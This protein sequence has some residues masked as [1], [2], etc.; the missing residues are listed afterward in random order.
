MKKIILIIFLSLILGLSLKSQNLYN[1]NLFTQNPEMYNPS[2]IVNDDIASFYLTSR[3]QWTGFEGLPK[4]NAAGASISLD[5]KMSIGMTIFNS[6]HGVLNNMKARASY[7]YSLKL[8]KKHFLK[9]G[10]SFGIVHDRLLFNQL[11]NVNTN[12]LTLQDGYYNKMYFSSAFG[13]FYKFK[14]LETQIILPQ[15]YEYNELNLY[16][17]AILAYDFKVTYDVSVK[18]TVLVRNTELDKVQSDFYVNVYWRKNLWVQLGAR[19]NQSLIFG[20]GNQTIGYSYE[21]AF[22]P[23]T[24]ASYGTHEILLKFR[25]IKPRMCP[26]YSK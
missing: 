25:I 21:A 10:L 26:A 11:E 12:D 20:V 22:N 24:G 18:P 4:Y 19:T 8:G 5:P 23:I 17:L 3:L 6:T 2:A 16:G 1:Y 9:F 14:G 7:G 15:L 13:L